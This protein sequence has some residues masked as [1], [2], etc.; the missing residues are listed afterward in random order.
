MA[1]TSLGSRRI[2]RGA[3]LIVA[4]WVLHRHKSY[5]RDPDLFDPDRFSSEREHDLP[6]NAYIPFGL[7]PR[8]CSGAAF[9]S[10]EAVLIIASLIRAF[11]IETLDAGKVTPAARLTTRPTEQILCRVKARLR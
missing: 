8:I 10:V 3:L 5:W 1:D 4:P 7:G 6:S 9:A 11:D 2:K